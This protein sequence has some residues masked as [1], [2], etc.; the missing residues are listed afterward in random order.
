MVKLMKMCNPLLLCG[1]IVATS[2]SPDSGDP[3][4][5][6]SLSPMEV[7][8]EYTG[9]TRNVT[10]H[11]TVDDS[12]SP[13]KIIS[14][15]PDYLIVEP[16]SGEGTTT[17][18]LTAMASEVGTQSRE[19][20]TFQNG[21]E[22]VS[23]VVTQDPNPVVDCYAKPVEVL[24][25]S[26]GIVCGV[27]VGRSCQYYYISIYKQEVANKMGDEKLMED[28][29]TGNTKGLYPNYPESSTT[30]GKNL[31]DYQGAVAW[32]KGIEP[33]TDYYIVTYAYTAEGLAGKLTKESISTKSEQL[34]P[35]VDMSDMSQVEKGDKMFYQW[36]ASMTPKCKC[37]FMYACAGEES[38][39]SF[40]RDD[41]GLLLA[42]HIHKY[43]ITEKIPTDDILEN[44]GFNRL[45]YGRE[46]L[47]PKFM[48]SGSVEVEKHPNDKYLEVV[49][50][51]YSDGELNEE[52]LSGIIT[53][54][55]ID[56]TQS[57]DVTLSVSPASLSFMAT[58]ATKT[59]ALS[60]NDEWTVK[61]QPSWTTV[62]PNSGK[63]D[64]TI[65]VTVTENT[66]TS[67][68]KGDIIIEGK[69][70]KKTVT[71][72]VVQAGSQNP[73]GTA[74][75]DRNDYGGDVSIDGGTAS[76]T[77]SLSASKLEYDA[78]GGQDS[79]SITSND[80]W[81]V[82]VTNPSWC[83]VSP[84]SGSGNGTLQVTVSKNTTTSSRVTVV[85][86]K[87]TRSGKTVTMTIK[88]LAGGA[89]T[90]GKND[91]PGDVTLD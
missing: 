47:Y 74:D 4:Y 45:K 15:I 26:N 3:V 29:T 67:E 33:N 79:V 56:L 54:K 36:T 55:K 44:V 69:N 1:L 8:F 48:N 35:S 81:N 77:L 24:G 75:I 2:C 65:S 42:W 66:T 50:L 88:Q 83:S 22:E 51:G 31:M 87:G 43:V 40:E 16:A 84:S 37:Y 28:I 78:G 38:F 46:Y 12:P 58:A 19:T 59:F 23:L 53:D 30:D 5:K 27:E 85:S 70:S 18:S 52:T 10:V 76:L 86:V 32:Y 68:R 49:I 61:T 91:Y 80:S 82:T 62:S 11:S 72:S 20:I 60:G 34:Q 90:I 63:G 14:D 41:N 57:P 71:V 39:E 9:G 64:A 73:D 25:M 7:N 21:E 13:W 17:L 89:T 6:I